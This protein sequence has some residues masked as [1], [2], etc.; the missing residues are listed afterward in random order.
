MSWLIIFL[1]L[2]SYFFF[3]FEINANRTSY[4]WK[5]HNT[6]GVTNYFSGFYFFFLPPLHKY[7]S[8]FLMLTIYMINDQTHK[9]QNWNFEFSLCIEKSLKRIV[10]DSGYFH[11]HFE[12]IPW[13][14]MHLYIQLFECAYIYIYIDEYTRWEYH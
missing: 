7:E 14:R 1:A 5:L 12:D 6:L 3:F 9:T 8:T 10:S 13:A 2:E 11:S 4:T